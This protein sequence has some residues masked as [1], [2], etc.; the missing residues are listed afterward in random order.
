MLY[1][2]LLVLPI[3]LFSFSCNGQIPVDS[4]PDSVFDRAED[5]KFMPS[6]VYQHNDTL[7][8]NDVIKRNIKCR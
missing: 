3:L 4:I 8:I 2:K 5:G 6:I 1:A 7:L